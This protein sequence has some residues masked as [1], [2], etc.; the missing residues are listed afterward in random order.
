L[1]QQARNGASPS[2][3]R[4]PEPAGVRRAADTLFLERACVGREEGL[5]RAIGLALGIIDWLYLL[6]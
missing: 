4:T 1:P 2:W 3:K 6:G 5:V